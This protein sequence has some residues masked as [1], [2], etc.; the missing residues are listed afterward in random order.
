VYLY[1]VDHLESLVRENAQHR[2]QE[3]ARCQTIISER[4]MALL[5]KLAPRPEKAA[6]PRLEPQQ[7]WVLSGATA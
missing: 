1:N 2:E 6:A 5:P 7:D 4:T 3:L